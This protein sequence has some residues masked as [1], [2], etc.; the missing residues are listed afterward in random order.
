MLSHRT[1]CLL[2]RPFLRHLIFAP[3]SV[4]LPPFIVLVMVMLAL[5]SPVSLTHKSASSLLSAL[6]LSLCLRLPQ[7]SARRPALPSHHTPFNRRFHPS[8]LSLPTKRPVFRL[9]PFD[10]QALLRRRIHLPSPLLRL[11]SPPAPPR[12]YC[13]PI[14]DSWSWRSRPPPP[15]LCNPTR[16]MTTCLP[17]LGLSPH[18]LTMLHSLSSP[19]PLSLPPA[20]G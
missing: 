1:Y 19:E 17:V 5:W 4:Y 3:S 2:A 10:T 14:L 6:T 15:P 16:T 20:P 8:Y 11:P 13:P 7:S 18:L 9:A 12:A